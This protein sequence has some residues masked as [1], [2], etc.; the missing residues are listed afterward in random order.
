MSGRPDAPRAAQAPAPAPPP[1]PSAS[2]RPAYLIVRSD[3]SG[4]YAGAL[5]L[6]DAAGLPVDFRFTDPITPTRLQRALYGGVLDRH[7]R[8]DVVAR[9]LVGALAERPGVLLVDDRHLLAPG[10][11]DCPVLMVSTSSAAPLGATG[12]V[13]GAGDSVLVQACEG[14][15]P[16]RVTLPDGADEAR[17]SAAASLVVALGETMDPLEPLD[18]VREALDLIAAGEVE[19]TG[20]EAA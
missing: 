12:A 10:V 8:I 16:V 5:M 7:L 2:V 9:T 19:D 6:T 17:R 18:R 1:P 3:P 14:V 13:Q 15:A 11:A 4:A 20:A